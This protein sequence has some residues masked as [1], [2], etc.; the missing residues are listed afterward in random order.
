MIYRAYYY[1]DSKHMFGVEVKI[2][3][4]V[5]TLELATD[6]NRPRQRGYRHFINAHFLD[7]GDL[8]MDVE[9]SKS[10]FYNLYTRLIVF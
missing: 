2:S 10:I 7:S 4:V 8:K 9:N 3:S 6:I 5:W 1:D